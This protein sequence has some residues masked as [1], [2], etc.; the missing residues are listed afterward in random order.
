[1]NNTD[2]TK[3]DFEDFAQD[4]LFRKWILNKDEQAERFWQ[5][6]I[7]TNPDFSQK[8]QLAKAFLYAL[9]EKDTSLNIETLESITDE[10][11]VLPKKIN[12]SLAKACLAGCC[13]SI[14]HFWYWSLVFKFF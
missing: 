8:I 1:M 4:T 12:P 9:E 11:A 14:R 10:V 3:F 6:W 2:Y 13:C 5:D 7:N